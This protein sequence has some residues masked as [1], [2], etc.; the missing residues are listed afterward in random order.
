MESAQSLCRHES[1]R[2]Y[3]SVTFQ[4]TSYQWETA[5]RPGVTKLGISAYAK[6][7]GLSVWLRPCESRVASAS[8]S[9]EGGKWFVVDI[10]RRL[11]RM[12]CSQHIGH[13]W[14]TETMDA[15]TTQMWF[16]SSPALE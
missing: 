12:M 9:E 4:D 16:L 6:E 7:R 8:L 5:C 15:I 10:K 1:L 13:T 3:L 14:S 11:S 2:C